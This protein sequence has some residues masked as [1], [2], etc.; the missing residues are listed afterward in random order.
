MNFKE[1]C[2][3]K[4]GDGL[5]MDELAAIE[6]CPQPELSYMGTSGIMLTSEQTLSHGN[7][8]KVHAN[9]V[10]NGQL[11]QNGSSDASTTNSTV[12]HANSNTS[13]GRVSNF[14]HPNYSIH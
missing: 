14:I 2:K 9:D 8:L 7:M 13:E 6:A 5:W 3:K 12:N 4:H 11:G 1:I 10:S